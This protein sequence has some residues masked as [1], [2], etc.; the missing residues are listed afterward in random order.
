MEYSKKRMLGA[1][2]QNCFNGLEKIIK[3]YDVKTVLE[4]GSGYSSYWFA[5][6]VEKLYTVD[7]NP[8][9]LPQ[10]LNNTICIQINRSKVNF[11]KIT[12]IRKDYDLVLVDCYSQNDLRQ[13]SANYVMDN[14]DW[15]ILCIHDWGRD[16]KKYDRER[17]SKF[18]QISCGELKTFINKGVKK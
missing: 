15:K 13:I 16:R 4:F 17:L 1:M 9:W 5:E 14:L 11:D 3:K 12:S 8:R 6:R 2:R 18:E 10:N 7:T